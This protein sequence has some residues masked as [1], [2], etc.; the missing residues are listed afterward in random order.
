MKHINELVKTK[1]YKKWKKLLINFINKIRFYKVK[2][3]LFIKILEYKDFK[4]Q[5]I[6]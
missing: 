5:K 2:I 6:Y 1:T 4:D 3:I